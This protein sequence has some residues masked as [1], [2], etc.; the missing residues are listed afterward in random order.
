MTLLQLVNR[1]LRR[2]REDEVTDF[3]ADYTTLIVD[4]LGEIHAEV[5]DEHDWSSMDHD[6][7]VLG[8]ASQREYDLSATTANGGDVEVGYSPTTEKSLVRQIDG[9]PVAYWYTD[10]SSVQGTR[11]PQISWEQYYAMYKENRT[12]TADQ[13]AYFALTQRA[14]GFRLAMWPAPVGSGGALEIRFHTPETVISSESSITTTTIKAPERPLVLGALYLALNERGEELGEPGNIA[15]QRYYKA[16][17]AA[18][19]ADQMNNGRTNKFEF[20]RD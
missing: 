15:E 13:P 10:T 14:D 17:A 7:R 20:Y 3:S 8:V 11:I 5:L 12:D 18:K 1:V 9:T 4:F 16:L 2:L 6:L 19:E